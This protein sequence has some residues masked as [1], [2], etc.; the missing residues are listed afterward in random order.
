MSQEDLDDLSTIS[1]QMDKRRNPGSGRNN[2]K[3]KK[4]IPPQSKI[5]MFAAGIR[6]SNNKPI[7]LAKINLRELKEDEK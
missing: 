6:W 1:E 3:K 7:T 2:H 5:G 4:D